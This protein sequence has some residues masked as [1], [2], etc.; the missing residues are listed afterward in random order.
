M[1]CCCTCET[2]TSR[3]Q[4]HLTVQLL[5]QNESMPKKNYPNV[6][7]FVDHAPRYRFFSPLMSAPVTSN[8]TRPMHT[9]THGAHPRGAPT[10]SSVAMLLERNS[11][12]TLGRVKRI[13]H[14]I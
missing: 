13:S 3:S 2:K 5:F 6:I 9:Q 8:A 14:Q 12:R 1:G 7:I 11:R 10:T 4:H